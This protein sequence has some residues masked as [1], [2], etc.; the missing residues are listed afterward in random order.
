MLPRYEECGSYE[1]SP[2]RNKCNIDLLCICNF[3]L[4][5]NYYASFPH[6]TLHMLVLAW[7]ECC[8]T[9]AIKT[10]ISCGEKVV[11][12]NSA[13]IVA[14]RVYMYASGMLL[15]FLPPLSCVLILIAIFFTC[16]P[17]RMSIVAT[18]VSTC[19][20]YFICLFISISVFYW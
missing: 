17:N 11:F 13:L 18:L 19:A 16:M 12:M 5:V 1:T 14:L 2:N 4:S 20:L 15:F 7:S 6:M 3:D 8:N 9:L 10:S